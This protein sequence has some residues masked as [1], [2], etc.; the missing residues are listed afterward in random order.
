VKITTPSLL[1][2]RRYAAALAL[3]VGGVCTA[4]VPLAA[5]TPANPQRI[6]K[7]LVVASD[8]NYPPYIFRDA[9]GELSGYLVDYWKLWEQKTGIRV[10][11]R[12]SDWDKAKALMASG[13]AD[14][15]DTIFQTPERE[16]TLD[17]TAPY[18]Q[19]PV[20]IYAH[21]GIGGISDLQHLKG[22]LVGAKDGDACVDNLHAAGIQDVKTYSSYDVLVKS[23]I[24]GEVKIFCLDEPPAN[25][26][27]YKFKA[28]ETFNI[29]FQI[30]TGEFHRAVHKGDAQTLDT[31]VRGAAKITPREDAN[32]RKKWM[33]T[34]LFSSDL[35]RQFAYVLAIAL[36]LGLGLF[37]W[38][39]TLRQRVRDKTAELDEERG[40][41]RTLL[42]AIPDL[43]WLK[44]KDG[45]YRYCNPSFERFFG[46]EEAAIVGKT[47]FD[48]VAA[49]QAAMFRQ[50]D[51]RA[52][53]AGK[54][55]KNEEWITFA[56]DGHRAYLETTKTPVRDML[57]ELVG[58]LGVARDITERFAAEEQIRVLAFYDSLT[59]LPNRRLLNDRLQQAL[60]ASARSGHEGALLF[61]DLDHFKVLNDTLGHALGDALLVEVAKRIGSQVR[62]GDTVARL[63]GDE[64][65]V[66]LEGL[67]QNA[68]E[69][70]SQ[71]E[72]VGDKVLQALSMPYALQGQDY[73]GSASMGIALFEVGARNSDE[74]MKR[75]DLAMYG[76]K[77]S[78]RNTLRFFDPAMQAAV[79][80][81]AES[82]KDLRAALHAQQF[83]L[84]FQP[85]LLNGAGV[86]GAEC[87]LRWEHPG[88]G[89]I[90]PNDFIPLAEET[91]IIVPLGQWVLEQ[92][93]TQLALWSKQPL[94]A[95]LTLAV[96][97]SAKQ[98][99]QDDFVEQ[100][101]ETLR[102]TGA[103]PEK[104]E[105]ELTEGLLITRFDATA[106]KM[107]ALNAIGVRFS[108]DDFGTGFSS[109]LYL[110][111]LPFNQLKIDKS[112]V[113]NLPDE[114]NDVSIATAVI[115]LGKGLGLDVIAEGV[116]T[117]AQQ[118]FLVALGC[119][120]FQGFLFSRPLPIAAFSDFIR[121]SA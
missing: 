106:Q 93:C 103:R 32:L 37:M 120:R 116:E 83:V 5:D 100:V 97:V 82:E 74:L 73:R 3:A 71:A 84:H 108:L 64:F 9:S 111:R 112:F 114:K 61:V 101:Q 26:L 104:L 39:H 40:R 50:N 94:F 118:N 19:I 31:L 18:A 52:I 34:R 24:A 117:P 69:A 4:Q 48:F 57:G 66:M 95:H 88:R 17:F 59:Q 10:N 21:S 44:D 46:A 38:G 92:A 1:R 67:S 102:S 109:L 30:S 115:A 22:F 91:G 41:L 58:V 16:Q 86:V 27:L 42:N 87:L 13:Q 55:S 65:V 51:L 23:A 99:Y 78:G 81:R 36:A 28:D 33:G 68:V 85:Q 105:L 25:Y 90:A 62:E 14:V 35:S 110:K 98:F 121:A 96:N 79:I 89:T 76:A 72:G 7:E 12:A 77:A 80:T 15:I 119:D 6:K 70:A 47:D 107:A 63:G 2:L 8:D 45:I 43:V 53:S 113:R 56:D 49:E 20:A 29:A 60:L 75:A 11:L 54:S